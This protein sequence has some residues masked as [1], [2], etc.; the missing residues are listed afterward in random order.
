MDSYTF[1]VNILKMDG[2]FFFYCR[3]LEKSSFELGKSTFE[4]VIFIPLTFFYLNSNFC[5]FQILTYPYA[6]HSILHK[7]GSF[8]NLIWVYIVDFNPYFGSTDYV[9]LRKSKNCNCGLSI[10]F[11]QTVGFI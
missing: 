6:S 4:L 1:F 3:V 7:T 8:K 5:A 2:F 11:K 9:L 10:K